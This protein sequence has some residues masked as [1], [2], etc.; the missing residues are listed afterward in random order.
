MGKAT[1][2]TLDVQW[3]CTKPPGSV[4]LKDHYIRTNY[5]Y[6]ASTLMALSASSDSP[7][8]NSL[9]DL[10]SRSYVHNMNWVV[11]KALIKLSPTIKRTVCKK[12]NRR[13]ISGKNCSVEVTNTSNLKTPVNDILTVSCICQKFKKNYPIGKNLNYK[14]FAHNDNLLPVK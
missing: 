5:L 1:K 11:K 10:L 14:I 6:Q 13:L 7:D 8:S 3:I 4:S 12:C 9:N 2:H